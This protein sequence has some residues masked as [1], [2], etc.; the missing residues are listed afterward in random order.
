MRRRDA[1]LTSENCHREVENGLIEI[2]REIRA[3]IERMLEERSGGFL[4]LRGARRRPEP[5]H[6]NGRYGK[7]KM[8]EAAIA[9]E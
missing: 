3:R 4:V 5:T 1:F 6:E 7:L 9:Q 2:P 8:A